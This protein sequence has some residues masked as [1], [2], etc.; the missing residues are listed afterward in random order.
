MCYVYSR[1]R[2]ARSAVPRA[3]RGAG[4]DDSVNKEEE[5]DEEEEKD[6]EE[7]SEEQGVETK[8][9]ARSRSRPAA[10]RM[11]LE[12]ND[13]TADIELVYRGS[14]EAAFD[15]ATNPVHAP[16]AS[17]SGSGVRA[18]KGTAGQFRDATTT[19]SYG[20]ALERVEQGEG[21]GF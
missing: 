8:A 5:E 19:S 2:C 12:G 10:V 16:T 9:R 17:A 11:S 21:R 1:L 7:E 13:A 4:Q 14:G 6:G 3:A 18:R 15:V 20:E